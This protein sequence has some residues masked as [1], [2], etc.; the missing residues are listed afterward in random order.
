MGWLRCVAPVEP[1]KPAFPKEKMPPSEAT[2]QYPPPSG[3]EA[4][5]TM[6]LFSLNLPVD[7]KNWALPKVKMPPSAAAN[8]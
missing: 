8:L 7:P 4:T 2:S 5:V 1:K 6:G 3:V